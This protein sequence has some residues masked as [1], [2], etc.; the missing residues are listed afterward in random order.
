MDMADKDRHL[1]Y[2]AAKPFPSRTP[3]Q[4]S[5]DH[6]RL[7]LDSVQGYAIIML[8]PEGRITS[9]NAG[10]RLI[11]G[12]HACEI[13]GRHCSVLYPEEDR[14]AGKPDQ[15]LEI[16]A[17]DGRFEEEGWRV[18]RDGSKFWANVAVTALRDE[19]GCLYGFGNVTRDVTEHKLADE[20][21]RRSEQRFRL[22]VEEVRDYAIFMLDAQG[23]ISSW[24]RGARQIKGYEE[25]EILG[26][27]FSIFYPEEDQHAGKPQRALEIAAR[28][29]RIED[30]GWR[31]RKDGALFWASVV[32]TALKDDTGSLVGFAKVTRDITEKMRASA[33]L[34]RFNEKLAR[35]IAEKIKAQAQLQDSE[36]SL[37]NL[38]RHLLRTQDEERRR[39]G[40]DLHDSVGQYLA[41]LKMSLDSMK[42]LLMPDHP[43]A[44]QALTQCT[45]LVG[46]SIKEVRTIAYLLY[47]P[48]LEET[49]LRSAI[50]WYLE[51]FA[52]RSGIKTS[53]DIPPDFGRLP[54]D[55]ELAIFRVLQESLT[56]VHRHSGSSTA[57]VRV[58]INDGRATLEVKDRGKGIPKEILEE[59]HKDSPGA[60]GVGLRGMSERMRQLGGTVE[61]SSNSD[62]TTVVAK[63]PCNP[64]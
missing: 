50:Q 52:N 21:L 19:D 28:E 23:H 43:R 6:F 46:E 37:R 39:I 36:Q 26:K 17:R 29:G 7:L 41:V 27:H 11:E 4:Q 49:G 30:E 40:R 10:A 8:D 1:S 38:S 35:E 16:A 47:P 58:S 31:V 14:R 42:S 64:E 53:F 48:M 62:G 61:L 51:G 24:N 34:Q 3:L 12:Y 13:L 45:D 54:R 60:L 5:G 25:D 56:N 44:R 59:S 57:H 9:W 63:V 55:V 33:D 20:A 18:R 32:I 2:G 22:L 15:H